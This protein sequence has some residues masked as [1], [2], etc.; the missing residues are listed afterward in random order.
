MSTLPQQ[1]T[2]KSRAEKIKEAKATADRLRRQYAVAPQGTVMRGTRGTALFGDNPDIYVAPS[3]TQNAE[4]LFGNALA[5]YND[6]QANTADAANEQQ[7]RDEATGALKNFP[8]TQAIR[9]NPGIQLPA[10]QAG[11]V[12]PPSTETYTR[13]PEEYQTALADWGASVDPS[14]PY[15]AGTGSAVLKESM[16]SAADQYKQGAAMKI[17]MAANSA[18]Q[19]DPTSLQEFKASHPGVDMNDP[20]VAAQYLEYLTMYRGTTAIKN[21]QATG[22]PVGKMI[23]YG[24]AS[25]RASTEA[26]LTDQ[27]EKAAAGYYQEATS[28]GLSGED[29]TRF[30]QQRAQQ[31]FEVGRAHID[32]LF[33]LPQGGQQ[34][35]PQVTNELMPV[36]N[37]QPTGQL[38]PMEVTNPTAPDFQEPN[39][40]AGPMVQ[41]PIRQASDMQLSPLEIAEMQSSA[42][43]GDQGAIDT[44]KKF[45]V[46]YN[47]PNKGTV[48]SKTLAAN[49]DVLPSAGQ[50]ALPKATG[51]QVPPIVDPIKQKFDEK[52]ATDTAENRVKARNSL[53]SLISGLDK[54]KRHIAEVTTMPAYKDVGTIKNAAGIWLSEGKGA[55]GTKAGDFKLAVDQLINQTMKPAYDDIR[56]SGAVATAEGQAAMSAYHRLSSSSTKEAFDSALKDFVTNY[57]AAI[58]VVKEQAGGG[59]GGG[60]IEAVMRKYGK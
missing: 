21:A 57:E 42:N 41:T 29:A 32:E 11:P 49:T 13:S 20:A 1:G 45:G 33:K 2:Y 17:K 28:K 51:R 52:T 43:Q 8:R 39:I 25:A 35:K 54:V 48:L 19:K 15:L 53:P 46:P 27:I 23:E 58:K 22:V 60:D 40:P 56:G 55:I 50:P 31:D 24:N 47:G 14:N 4:H 38:S 44:L 18:A 34:Q 7:A 30:A 36:V 16:D 12:V 5:G 3:W 10:G 26:K 6:R 59:A 37:G 9:E